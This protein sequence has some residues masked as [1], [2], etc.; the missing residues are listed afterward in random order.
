MSQSITIQSAPHT[1]HII[2]YNGPTPLN[3]TLD[4]TG[5]ISKVEL[6]P[7][8]ETPSYV[9]LVRKSG[10]LDTWNGLTPQEALAK[11][12]DA[13]SGAT[14]TSRAIAQTLHKRLEVYEAESAGFKASSMIAFGV[15]IIGIAMLIYYVFYRRRLKRESSTAVK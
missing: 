1:N 12:V 13:V 5:K 8:Q 15:G 6:L 2:G 3:I 9:Q 11:R 4:E 7:H 14:Y 10:L